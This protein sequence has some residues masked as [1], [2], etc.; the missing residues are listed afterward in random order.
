MLQGG[1]IGA[2]LSLALPRLPSLEGLILVGT[3]LWLL[4]C[5][6]RVWQTVRRASAKGENVQKQLAL[7][8]SLV[9][10]S[11]LSHLHFDGASYQITGVVIIVVSLPFFLG[12]SRLVLPVL[13]GCVVFW[14]LVSSKIAPSAE[15]VSTTFVVSLA[16]LVSLGHWMWLR[17]RERLKGLEEWQRQGKEDLRAEAYERESIAIAA[18]ENGHWYW[19]LR[20]DVIQFSSSWARMLGYEVDQLGTGPE[21]WFSQVHPYSLPKLK[22]A[23]SAHL[24]G[25]TER[26][27]SQYRIQHQDGTLLWV[28]NRGV[29]LRDSDGIAVAIAG[30]Q[31]NI[32]ELVDVEKIVGDEAYRDRLTGL[33]NREALVIRLEQAVEHVKRGELECFAVMFLDLDRFKVVNDSLGHLVGDQLL[34]AVSARL[35]NCTRHE[36]GDLIARF[37]G[38]EFAVLIEEPPSTETQLPASDQALNVATRMVKAMEDPFRLGT[39]EIRTGVSIGIAL[40]ERGVE[41]AEDLLR[42]ADTAMYHAKSNGRGTIEFFSS[43]MHAAAMRLNQLQNDL[44][45]ALERGELAVHYQPIVSARSGRIVGAEALIRW[46]H[47][48]GD[49]IGPSEFIPIAEEAGLLEPIDKWVLR[50]ACFQ[51]LDWQHAGLPPLK[52][53]VNVSPRQLRGES[54]PSHV[55]DLLAESGVEPGLLE[56]ELTETALMSDVDSVARTIDELAE[57]G[58]GIALDDFGTGYSSLEHLRSFRFRT[59][60]MD[61][62]FVAGLTTDAKAAAVAR[63]LINL[64]HQLQLTVTAEGVETS[65][66]L[67]FLK[68]HSCDRIQGFYASRPLAPKAFMKLLRSDFNLYDTVARA[69]AS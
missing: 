53:S 5:V 32:T 58:V 17:R 7:A 21:A 55:Q 30:S 19:D 44:A 64:A 39:H 61:R 43:N 46:R 56:F 1:L 26:F 35:R 4:A 11:P 50:T 37:G 54:L 67:S 27:Q 51:C 68:S 40:W 28:M 13:L 20:T 63:G 57:I 33:A 59:L 6:W 24:Y 9:L 60:K 62:S 42:N 34:A 8:A 31:I 25:K 45:K 2:N 23:L 52:V 16:A 14:A 66:E 41:R 38:D 10:I 12:T 36:A 29:A 49:M 69:K 47:P 3:D 48:S 18:S 22:E 65:E 15:L